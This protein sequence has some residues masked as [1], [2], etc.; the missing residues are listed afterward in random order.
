MLYNQNQV[1]EII[2]QAIES[3]LS[4]ANINGQWLTTAEVVKQFKIS[5]S[6]LHRL[7]KKG[8]LHPLAIGRLLKWDV[9]ELTILENH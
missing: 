2:R 4:R 6:T 9:K 1:D 8:V 5:I 3:A 7:K